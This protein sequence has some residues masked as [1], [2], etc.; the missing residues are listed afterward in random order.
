MAKTKTQDD[1]TN[2]AN[3]QVFVDLRDR[4]SKAI[5][6]I[7]RLRKE[8]AKLSAQVKTLEAD[9][10][11][12]GDFSLGDGETPEELKAKIEG[13]IATIESMLGESVEATN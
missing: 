12:S 6:E 11:G 10:G 13:F 9:G 5:K 2:L 4:V 3:L 7:E 8:N 1:E